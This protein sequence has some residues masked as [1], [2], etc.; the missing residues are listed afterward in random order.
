VIFC[1]NLLMKQYIKN[2][3]IYII[4]AVTFLAV[5]YFFTHQYDLSQ[6][7]KIIATIVPV[8]E[9]N[10]DYKFIYPLLTYNLSQALPFLENKTL[11]NKINDYVQLQYKNNSAQTIGVYYRNLLTN[12]WAGINQDVKFHPGSMMKVMIMMAYYRE[13]QLD[14]AIMQ[15]EFNYSKD[16]NQVLVQQS[17]ATPSSLVVG[18]SYNTKYLIEK[19]I[20]DSDNGAEVLLYNNVNVNILNDVYR[21]LSLPIPDE[22]NQ[23]Y[24]ISARQYTAFLRILYNST[25]LAELNSEEALS[26]MSKSTYND[27]IYAGVPSNIV[28]AEKYGERVDT[29]SSGKNISSVELSNCGIVY[30]TSPYTLCVM[31]KGQND[32]KNLA[33]IIKDI[34]GIVYN[35]V[36]LGANK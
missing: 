23:N 34:S 9:N 31:T 13:S 11:T 21:D 36:S 12:G 6:T 25:Y 3:L 29:D 16:I 10:F 20:E 19:M 8:R 17:Y 33:S 24:T 7:K 28:V 27:G 2:I 18:Q 22:T 15:K 26:I 30:A 5:G 32:P 4:V 35:Y 1:Y 14:P